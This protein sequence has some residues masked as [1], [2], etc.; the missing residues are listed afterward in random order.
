VKQQVFTLQWRTANGDVQLY[1]QKWENRSSVAI[2]S[3]DLECGQYDQNGTGLAQKH[4]QLTDE[5][6]RAVKPGST[7]EF[8]GLDIGPAVQG[9]TA[10]NCGIVNVTPAS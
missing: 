1:N 10:L 6:D 3:S 2:Q 5:T 7:E 4:V 9:L 8:S